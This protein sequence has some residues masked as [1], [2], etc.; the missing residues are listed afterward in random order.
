MAG[1]GNRGSGRPDRLG[2][3]AKPEADPD[4]KRQHRQDHREALADSQH[5]REGEQDAGRGP[6]GEVAEADQARVRDPE[7]G[8]PES[9]E[10][11]IPG[12]QD[13]ELTREQAEG[14]HVTPLPPA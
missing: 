5:E 6:A 10:Q 1:L 8:E 4:L 11:G 3:S 9:P 13:R 14:R 2:L 7:L 12:C